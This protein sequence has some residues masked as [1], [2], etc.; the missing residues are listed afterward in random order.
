MRG[1][2][3]EYTSTQNLSRK[4]GNSGNELKIFAYPGETPIIK[5]GSG[6]SYSGDYNPIV[7]FSG[8]Y[9]HWKG[10]E[11]TGNTQTKGSAIYTG[12]V[13]YASNNCIFELLNIH[14]N[15]MGF[16]LKDAISGADSDNN[17]FLNCDFHHNMD[18]LTT[19]DPYGN[20]DGIGININIGN[21][22]TLRGCRM[23]YNSDDGIDPFG[24]DATII[25]DK[26]W[27]FYN[28]LQFDTFKF[29]SPANGFKLG[30]TNSDHGN[31]VLFHVTN[32]LAY[33]NS[34]I[35][36]NQNQSSAAI[37]AYNNILP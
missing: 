31:T 15:G 16:W 17:L 25:I 36:Y 20:A 11:I 19:G 28:G 3:Y 2:T 7:R 5:R 37:E 35:G 8:N 34:W 10:L 21:T 27:A 23:Y 14:H 26:C 32:C 29:I 18:P 9:V 4:N 1:G 6:F 24:S 13:A 30:G 22:V 12:M 33:R